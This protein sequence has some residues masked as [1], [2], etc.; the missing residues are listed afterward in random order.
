MAKTTM[1][2]TGGC[3]CGAIRYRYEGEPIAVGLCQCERCQRQSG[4]AFLIGMVFPKKA[5]TIDGKLASYETNVSGQALQRHFCPVCGSAVS[6]TLERYPEIRS[7]MGGTLD[8]RTKIKPT[9]SIWC[10]SGQEWLKLPDSITCYPEYPEG[11]FGG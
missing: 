9:F 2:G 7:M 5:V 11:T 6:I 10:S 1:G 3:L 8:D 4:S